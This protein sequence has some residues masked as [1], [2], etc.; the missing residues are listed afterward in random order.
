MLN[1]YNPGVPWWKVFTPVVRGEN[2]IC[3]CQK[4]LRAKNANGFKFRSFGP[5]QE[6]N[7]ILRVFLPLQRFISPSHY[8]IV[9]FYEPHTPTCRFFP[10]DCSR[11]H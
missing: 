11:G 4:I 5:S 10:S 6:K 9:E 3:I 1:S 7:S 2:V 8:P